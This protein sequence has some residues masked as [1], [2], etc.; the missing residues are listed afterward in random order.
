LLPIRPHQIFDL[1]MFQPERLSPPGKE[2]DDRRT[3]EPYV[4]S[5]EPY[6]VFQGPRKLADNVET[7]RAFPAFERGKM[8]EIDK[9]EFLRQ[10]KILLEQPVPN[11]TRGRIVE[12]S[13]VFLKAYALDPRLKSLPMVLG[14]RRLYRDGIQVLQEPEI[15]CL[16]H[17]GIAVQI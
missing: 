11:K 7:M 6:P 17:E 2:I 5:T 10:R 8:R 15:Q 4:G 16:T 1:V 12:Q 13:F 9:E 14:F 3:V